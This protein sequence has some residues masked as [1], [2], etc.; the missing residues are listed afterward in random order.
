VLSILDASARAEEP[1]TPG[2]LSGTVQGP[3]GKPVVGARVWTNTYDTKTS[4]TKT[5]AEARTDAEGRFRLGPVEPI[6]RHRFD[7]IIDADGFA[8]RY[9][10]GET[11]SIFPGL[12]NDLGTIR[13]DRGR[14]F[15][16]QVLDT[17]GKPHPSATVECIIR[18]H[19][20]GHTVTY[21]GPMRTLTTDAE[22]RFRTPPLD[23][24]SLYLKVHAQERRVGS[25]VRPVAPGGEEALEPIRL[26]PDVPILGVVRN[27]RG[28]PLA[29]VEIWANDMTGMKS[30]AE[31]RFMIRSFG[32]NPRFQFRASKDGFV[33]V[34]WA[35]NVTND[36]IRWHDVRDDGGDFGP[37]KD[38]SVTMNPVAWIEGQALDADTG[39]PVR[40]EKIVL[41]FFT[42]KPNGETVLSG[43]RASRFEQ[44][45]TGRFRVPYSI[46]DEYHLTFSADGYH[47]AEVFT[48]KV[49][50]RKMIG[51]VV[52]R[53]K[54]K[55]EGSTPEIAKQTISGTVTREGQPIRTGW[56][57]L[58][59]M[60]RMPDTVNAPILRGRTVEPRPIV[61]ASTP[62]RDGSYSLD[63]PFQG[64]NWYVVA[65][66]P[67]R[68]L[69]QVG[70]IA[71]ALNQHKTMDI[72]CTEG[73]RLSGRVANVPRGWEGHLWV[74]A[75]TRTAIREEVR[76]GPDGT[77]S[78]PQLP[79]GEYGLKVGHDAYEDNEVPQGTFEQIPKE[80][81]ETRADPWK[82]AK[83]VTVE[84]GRDS[85]G[86]EL[87]LP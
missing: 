20:L 21:I 66:E 52:A 83:V 61:Y 15:T 35:V 49:S 34:N 59:A 1:T 76:V 85:A 58:W 53:M 74:V 87:E 43:C 50:E 45:E 5:L 86:V 8:R 23:V 73:R 19:Y 81:W 62:I 10:P 24:G 44:P 32:P 77:F 33:P 48:P 46:P 47:D 6:Y 22:G 57:G 18:R 28:I 55:T 3:D 78:F 39:E 31:G 30:D 41:C 71:I 56:V 11:Y 14:V 68:P 38:L 29:G 7:L 12:D 36:G 79:P 67:G 37:I 60:S 40:L 64:E 27:D 84:A 65:E 9:I 70:P 75:F 4:S 26:E 72:S 2:T 25:V 17:D 63:V 16:G 51:G 13:L 54:K 80:A 82:R 69:T 42:R